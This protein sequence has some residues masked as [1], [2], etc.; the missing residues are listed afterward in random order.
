MHVTQ[1]AVRPGVLT[2]LGL[3]AILVIVGVAVVSTQRNSAGHAGWH[4]WRRCLHL[5]LGSS[6]LTARPLPS[7]K[8]SPCA[9]SRLR[10]FDHRMR[11]VPYPSTTGQC[12]QRSGHYRNAIV[13]NLYFVRQPVC[14]MC[15]ELAEDVAHHALMEQ[16]DVQHLSA[17]KQATLE[18]L[19]ARMLISGAPPLPK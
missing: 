3:G 15:R 17:A 10:P 13:R 16:Q 12:P 4:A 6:L 9:C 19:R 1:E 11:S 8:P 2:W 18:R 5:R 7:V 14:H